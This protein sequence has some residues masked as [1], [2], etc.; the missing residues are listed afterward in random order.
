MIDLH[1]DKHKNNCSKVNN[2]T[3]KI[4]NTQD[5]VLEKVRGKSKYEATE[6]IREKSKFD[7]SAEINLEI[8]NDVLF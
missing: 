1:I 7:G 6:K 8:K 5:I 3:N 4:N 2:Q